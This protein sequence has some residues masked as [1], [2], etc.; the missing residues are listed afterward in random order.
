MSNEVL[1]CPHCGDTYYIKMVDTFALKR[2]KMRIEFVCAKCGCEF[3]AH[4]QRQSVELK[5]PIQVS[6]F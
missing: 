2:K 3:F 1:K 5:T 6:L 4:Y